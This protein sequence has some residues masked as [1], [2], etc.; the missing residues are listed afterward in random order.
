MRYSHVLGKWY[1]GYQF[2][3]LLN[4]GEDYQYV[5]YYDLLVLILVVFSQLF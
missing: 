5:N 4:Y 3:I 1:F 2:K